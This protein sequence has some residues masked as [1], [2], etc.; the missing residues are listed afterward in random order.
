MLLYVA[1]GLLV[2]SL[3]A[4]W[5]V[6]LALAFGAERLQPVVG[7]IRYSLQRAAALI[8]MGL[9]LCLALSISGA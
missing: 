1:V 4:V 2:T 6:G 8:Q 3:G 9:G 7:P 5:Y